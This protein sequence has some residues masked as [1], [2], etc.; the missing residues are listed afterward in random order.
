MWGQFGQTKILKFL[1]PLNALQ[2]DEGAIVGAF[3]GWI[4]CIRAV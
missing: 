3:S 2:Q 1:K 4:L